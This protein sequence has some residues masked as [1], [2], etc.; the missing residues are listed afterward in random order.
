MKIKQKNNGV[1]QILDTRISENRRAGQ[2]Q[3]GPIQQH[4][5]TSLSHG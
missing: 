5:V 1:F 3:G 4:Y 2:D